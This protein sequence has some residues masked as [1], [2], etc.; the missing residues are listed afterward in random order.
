MPLNMTSYAANIC[1]KKCE[2]DLLGYV[3][4]NKGSCWK[5]MVILGVLGKIRQARSE[6]KDKIIVNQNHL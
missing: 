3:E 5:E 6:Y 2:Q 4:K 1:L